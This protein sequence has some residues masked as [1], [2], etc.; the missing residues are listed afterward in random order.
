MFRPRW[1]RCI[2]LRLLLA[3]TRLLLVVHVYLQSNR[4]LPTSG[5]S[6]D[7]TYY[8]YAHIRCDVISVIIASRYRNLSSFILMSCTSKT[9]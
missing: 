8:W 7:T 6:P 2:G 3:G 4:A 5:Y 1:G 9:P